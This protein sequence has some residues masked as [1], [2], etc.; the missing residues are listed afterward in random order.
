[1]VNTRQST[2]EF[3]GPT[4]DEA[5]QRAVN[6]LLPDLTAQI[7]NELF[8]NSTGSN[9][10]QPPTINTWLERFGKHKPRSFSSATFLVDA[11]NWIAHIEKLFKVLGCADEFKARMASYKFEGDPLN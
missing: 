1:M 10:D 3:S 4:F 6:G 7:T 11:E 8:Q 5:V 9:G 2:L